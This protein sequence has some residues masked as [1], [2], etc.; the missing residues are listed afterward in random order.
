MNKKG[1]FQYILPII[2]PILIAKNFEYKRSKDYFELKM[3]GG[4]FRI[5]FSFYDFATTY[6]INIGVEIRIEVV[7]QIFN[8]YKNINPND[9]KDTFTLI[10]TLPEL[11]NHSEKVFRFNTV[12]EL[13]SILND[14]VVPFLETKIPYLCNQYNN[15]ENVFDYYYK[16]E[17]ENRDF[18]ELKYDGHI[19]PVIIAK[20]LKRN[21]FDKIIKWADNGLKKLQVKWPSSNEVECYE[22]FFDQMV[23]D[24]KTDFL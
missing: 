11:L 22:T 13:D 1:Y 10:L 15:L 12:G 4:W 8:R 6:N 7:Q 24:L 23:T 18:M 17:N 21:D 2:E 20:L 5:Q 3:A 19:I 16:P 14:K 9:F